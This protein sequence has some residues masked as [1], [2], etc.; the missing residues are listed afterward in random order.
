MTPSVSPRALLFGTFD[1][2][3]YGDLLFPIVAAHRLAPLGWDVVPVS[4][5]MQR[6]VFGDA[7]AVEPMGKLPGELRGDAVLVGGGE[8]VHAWPA[9]FLDEYRIGDLPT[10]AYP[11]LWLGA[12]LVGA[13]QDVPVIWN[14]PGV[15]AP[16]TEQIRRLAVEPVLAMADYVAVRDVPSR[17]FLGS[18][19]RAAVSVVPDSITELSRVWPLEALAPA[20]A[21]LCARKQIAADAQL[22]AVHLRAVGLEAEAI[23]QIAAM[24]DAFAS[25]R[26]LTPILIA[27]GPSLGD[28]DSVRRLGAAMTGPHVVLDD[29]LSLREIA[30][31]I[32][33]ARL[34]TGN[35]MHGYVTALSYGRPGVMI[36]RPAF[37]KLAGLA[38]HVQRPKDVVAEWPDALSRAAET[39]GQPAGIPASV[40]EALDGHWARVAAA[41]ADPAAGRGR[42]AD[43]LRHYLSGGLGKSGMGW[44]LQPLSGRATGRNA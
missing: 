29:P 43:F 18:T 20:F 9:S 14:A 1:V 13:L 12:S 26:G 44:L 4:P 28:D 2:A 34:Y 17:N 24:L 6:T 33:H 39:L 19:H 23:A 32:A 37:R 25:T 40:H 21:A 31:A 7:M 35:S 30:A 16:F 22:M 41:I 15:P 11:S 8:L 5:S 38:E 42:R 36:A 10:W 27:I 3:N